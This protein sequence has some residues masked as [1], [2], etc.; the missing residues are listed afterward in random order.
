MNKIRTRLPLLLLALLICCGYFV[1]WVEYVDPFPDRDSI[2][3]FYFPFLNFLTA[4]QAFD[5]SFFFLQ[6]QTFSSSYPWGAAL[7]PWLIS[8]FGAQGI[9][10]EN[11]FWLFI[12][13][14]PPILIIPL[15]FKLSPLQRFILGLFVF[16]IPMTQLCLKGFSLHGFNVIFTVVGV[17]FL[18][19]YMG[20]KNKLYLAGFIFFCWLGFI[21][22]HLGAF[23]LFNIIF[24]YSIYSIICR[25]TD[26]LIWISFLVTC[27]I[28]IPFYPYTKLNDYLTNVITHNPYLSV[29]SFFMIGALLM[30]LGA[31][32]LVL[33]SAKSSKKALPKLKQFPLYFSITFL[34]G[35]I[36]VMGS[37]EAETGN[38]EV[39]VYF[40]I[41]YGVLGYI[42]KN[43][44][45]HSIK[46]FLV[47]LIALTFINSMLLYCSR[48][49]Q[50]YHVFFLPILLLAIFEYVKIKRA[51]VRS[52][53]F[54]ACFIF[55]NF[56]PPILTLGHWIGEPGENIFINGFN[57]IYV[58][59]F[60]WQHCDIQALREEM[61]KV[62]SRV[63][64][65][66][67]SILWVV[68]GVH[69]YTKL[70]L[71]F[72][73]NLVFP[74]RDMYRIDNLPPEE[75]EKLYITY[76][77]IGVGIFE[78][79]LKDGKVAILMDGIKPYTTVLGDPPDLDQAGPKEE[80]GFNDFGR[81]LSFSY[82]KWLKANQFLDT[83]YKK[84]VIP[85]KDP[86]FNLY[87]LR[88]LKTIE[89]LDKWKGF[90]GEIAVDYHLEQQI[91]ELPTWHPKLN[92]NN[93]I[94]LNRS[95]AGHLY[96]KAD[97]LREENQLVEAYILLRKA[98]ELDP[99][100]IGALEDSLNVQRQL[101]K[102]DWTQLKGRYEP[103]DLN[104]LEKD[105]TE[106]KKEEDE[107]ILEPKLRPLTNQERA[108]QLFILSN[109]F[110][111]NEPE[112]AKELL[113]S[114]LKID[115]DHTDARKD[116]QILE[117]RMKVKTK[118]QSEVD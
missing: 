61:V 13:L 50:T 36:M 57:Y 3:Q 29:S 116:L 64:F 34:I 14:I 79:W 72:P 110:F 46:A 52:L 42:I 94:R 114:A 104:Q 11:P 90:L 70:A 112:R 37:H 92:Q 96:L 63:D 58:N 25:K 20:T 31:I 1:V 45:M 68:E 78:N 32:A 48:I 95:M 75:L 89:P 17:L 7:F 83:Y 86:R 35:I 117:E 49:G 69:F 55:S 85:S 39:I 43:Y 21:P 80:E 51:K 10:L 84:T 44:D 65:G 66:E 41:G 22:K 47:L 23:Y 100:H 67:N 82:L 60:G 19:S 62:F 16:F 108:H 30:L 77:D 59:P 40:L 115:P 15:F 98:L 6:S 106:S 26:K 54:L 81:S 5:P 99:N 109:Q 4:S 111:E 101:S 107:K 97:N 9:F 56:F 74:F 118:V 28:S 12:V 88:S 73:N 71:S 102:T 2:N 18:R 93:Q 38:I 24:T 103:L 113:K 87:T 105:F 76:Q 27:L 91:E 33:L 8:L 53:M